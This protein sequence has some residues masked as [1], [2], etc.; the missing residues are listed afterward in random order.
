MSK[1]IAID[2]GLK[3]SGIAYAEPPLYIAHPLQSMKTEN[4]LL[5][6]EDYLSINSINTIV[7]GEPKKLDGRTTHL[8]DSVKALKTRLVNKFTEIEIT[9]YDERFT[10]KLAKQTMLI[11]GV[12]KK[13]RRKKENVDLISAV[14]ILQDYLSANKGL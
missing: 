5:F 9:F 14:I 6:L 3:R 1:I 13:D 4:L 11:G 2:Y 10:S 7:I 8:S 12:K